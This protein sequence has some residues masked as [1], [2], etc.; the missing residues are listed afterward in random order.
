MQMRASH[1]KC[2][3][4][5]M[6]RFVSPINLTNSVTMKFRLPSSL[7]FALMLSFVSDAYSQDTPITGTVVMDV[8]QRIDNGTTMTIGDGS[9]PTDYSIAYGGDTSEAL[10][11][12]GGGELNLNKASLSSIPGEKQMVV[13]D[14][15]A[16]GSNGAG[17]LNMNQSSVDLTG[18]VT[19][20]VGIGPSG[21]GTVNVDNGSSFTGASN[22][23][24]LCNG[25]LNVTNKSSFSTSTTYRSTG[26]Y[27]GYRTILGY[28][29]SGAERKVDI[30][31]ASASS[32]ESGASRFVA[33][34]A[35]NS[36][37]NISVDGAGSSFTQLANV[38]S[39]PSFDT[40][41][42]LCDTG[43]N[44]NNEK[45]GLVN[46]AFVNIS[47]TNGGVVDF[48]SKMTYIGAADDKA[49]GYTNK[50]AT[51]KVGKGS[52]ISFKNMEVYANTTID[53]SGS[54]KADGVLSLYG[55]AKLD[56]LAS[57]NADAF[58]SVGEMQIKGGILEN[59]GILACGSI[60]MES[61]ELG[62]SGAIKGDI[63]MSGGVFT[64]ENGAVAGGLTATSGTVNL[65]GHVT[66]TGVVNLGVVTRDPALA[67]LSGETEP[68]LTVY[69]A[70]GT[71]IVLD[72]DIMSVDGQQ[73]VVG[74]DAQIIVD[75]GNVAYEEGTQLFT[76]SGSNGSQLAET[77]TNLEDR[78]TVTWTDGEGQ[79]QSASGAT[80]SG[81]I[82]TEVVPEP[83]TATL[84]LL[85]LAGMAMRRRRK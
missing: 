57:S 80:V 71:N 77:A 64:M 81:S 49:K 7:L 19:F 70:Q 6:A 39:E 52:S 5:P 50:M 78:V 34:G 55:G 16:N 37:I 83:A 30:N 27:S 66:F 13:G 61:G 15:Y 65:S 44:I 59:D 11:V 79:Q 72:A 14:S 62:N 69:I 3:K 67:L 58:T 60:F 22:S 74:D 2:D 29:G 1:T 73:F 24:W 47:A 56:I 18:A 23:L 42:Y 28:Y 8:P 54:F 51:F 75:L 33:C 43:T 10:I 46:N 85:A 63:S 35:Q 36:E 82:S 32:F 53:N 40:I 45:V 84:S 20:I 38:P 21:N 26:L 68:A 31:V 76:L 9:T 48:Q 41:T 25:T 12:T 17:T 4:L